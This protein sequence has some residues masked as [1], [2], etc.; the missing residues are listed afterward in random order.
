MPTARSVGGT[1]LCMRC[2]TRTLC[3][4]PD[5]QRRLRYAGQLIMTN[6][7]MALKLA[8][9]HFRWSLFCSRK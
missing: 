3:M 5:P 6:L 2:E 1:S 4:L 8:R 9:M 7:L